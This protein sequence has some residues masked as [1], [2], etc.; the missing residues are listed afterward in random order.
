MGANLPASPPGLVKNS[1]ESKLD[2]AEKRMQELRLAKNDNERHILAQECRE[3][4]DQAEKI[5]DAIRCQPSDDDPMGRVTVVNPRKVG[6]GSRSKKSKARRAL[7]TREKI[8]LLERSRLYGFVFPP[9]TSPPSRSEFEL[10][11]GQ[12]LYLYVISDNSPLVFDSNS[13]R[14]N[15]EPLLSAAQEAIFAGWKRPAEAFPLPFLQQPALFPN[16]NPTM[17]G[18]GRI[19]LV[20]D[21]TADCSVVASLC[22]ITARAERGHS[23]VVFSDLGSNHTESDSDNFSHYSSL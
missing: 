21:V 10:G 18:E 5:R 14:D 12:T 17:V 19:D 6:L 3:L 7:T 16:S 11:D 4:L 22:A 1:L 15:P 13:H 23:K 9:W 20:Q 8:I 2:A